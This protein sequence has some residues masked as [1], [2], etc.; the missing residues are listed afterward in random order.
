M[1]KEREKDPHLYQQL[2]NDRRFWNFF[3]QDFYSSVIV[4]RKDPVLQMQWIDWKSMKE[5]HNLVFDEV[6]AAGEAKCV[7]E[8]L[9]FKYNWCVR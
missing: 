4:L 3:Q 7:K 6:I 9:G 5:K 1:K 2:S 8:I